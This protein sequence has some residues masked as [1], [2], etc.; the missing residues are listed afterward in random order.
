IYIQQ[1]K[2]CS[3][4]TV[5][6]IH[7]IATSNLQVHCTRGG[8]LTRKFKMAF[9]D[10]IDFAV[11][12]YTKPSS[13]RNIRPPLLPHNNLSSLPALKVPSMVYHSRNLYKLIIN[14]QYVWTIHT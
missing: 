14:I 6:Y 2:L 9:D 4:A 11:Q 8:H 5:L 12:V 1:V 13:S 3:I 7:A 10:S